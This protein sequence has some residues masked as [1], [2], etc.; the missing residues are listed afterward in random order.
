M[1]IEKVNENQIRCMLTREELADRQIKLSELAYG[2]EKAKNLFRDMIEQ[3]NYEFGFEVDDIPVMIEAI[4]LSGENII[5]QITKVEYPEELDTRFSKF[6]EGGDFE[7]YEKENDKTLFS[8]LQGADDILGLFQQMKEDLTQ[9]AEE[10]ERHPE[11][12]GAPK[13]DIS[14]KVVEKP[15]PPVNL[16]K[17]FEAK[18]L[19]QLER[20]SHVLAGYYEGENDIYKDEVKNCF[21][22]LVRKTHHTP[23]E[24]NKVCNI[25]SEYA[26]YRKYTP[27]TEALMKE[28]GKVI[29]KGDALQ[30]LLTIGM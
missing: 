2:S 7:D 16:T 6:S 1:K 11:K 9:Q 24:F 10:K 5:L 21:Y 23:E 27:A 3:A 30:V 20:L 29:L 15:Q 8:D 13:E 12:I 26:V 4:P 28:H 19:D 25:I 14:N 22:L 17:L 18:S